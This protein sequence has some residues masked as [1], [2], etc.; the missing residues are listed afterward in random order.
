MFLPAGAPAAV[1]QKLNAEIRK[2]LAASDVREFMA[3]EGADPVGSSPEEL[4]AYFKR[5]VAKYAEV[6]RKAE[7]AIQ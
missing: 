1:V 6:I 7:I 2:A 3:R 4:A 5:E